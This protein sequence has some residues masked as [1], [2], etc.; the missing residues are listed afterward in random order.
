MDTV[1]RNVECVF[2]YLDDILIASSSAKQHL[3]DLKTVCERLRNFGLTIRLEK[4]L[5][6]VSSI[7]FLGH[8]VSKDG[9]VPLPSK[10]AAIQEFPKPHNVK[11]LQEF[12]GMINFYHRYISDAATI[13]RPLYCALKGKP[14]KHSLNWTDDMT[15]AFN[16]GKSALA[17]ATLLAHPRMDVPI[18][19]T[20]D[21]CDSGVGATF[22][23]F[24]DGSWQPLAFFSKQLR[25]PERKYSTFD[26]ELLALYLS[27]RHFRFL[28]EGRDFTAF[29]DHKPLVAAMCKVSDPWS[30]RQ[31]R[32]LSFISEF[33]TNVQHISGKENVV[34]DCLS[35]APIDNVSIGIDYKA[36]AEAQA[37]SEEVQ[38]YLTAITNLHLANMPVSESG[39]VLLCDISTGVPRPIV[40][41]EYR[42]LVFDTIHN[43]AHPGRKTTQ[44]LVSDKFVWHGIRK[45]VNQWAKECLQCQASKIQTHVRAPLENFTVPEKRFSHIHIDLVGPLPP[46]RGYS[47]LLT[48]VDRNT[49]WPEAIPMREI[50]TTECARALI[51]VWIA[52]FGIPLSMTSDRG[53]QFTSALWNAISGILGIQIHHT[54]AYHPQS[55]G[56]VER[57]HRT[58]KGSLKAR[59][60]GPNWIDELPWVMLGLRTAPKEDLHSSSAELVYGEP[61]TVPGDFASTNAVPRSL[62]MRLNPERLGSSV[63]IPTSAHS[64]IN[65]HVPN[66]LATARYVFIRHDAHRGPLQRPYDGPYEVISPGDKAFRI[67]VGNRE[68]LISIDRLKPAHVSPAIPVPVAQ[69]PRRGRPALNTHVDQHLHNDIGQNFRPDTQVTRAG[70]QVRLPDRFQSG[71]P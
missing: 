31:Q 14:P 43:L 49:R 22:E 8:N 24:V 23:Q 64:N 62:L 1:F 30:A 29:T 55:N 56:L 52:R 48:I 45:Q 21:A 35:R 68:E 44:K 70:R 9:S 17:S 59:L 16:E 3:V 7:D 41:P 2:V 19:V 39:P 54:T 53:P 28:L 40:P 25:E 47:Y 32:H 34:A 71:I 12:L 18:A 33:T 61:L 50:T 11:L 67:R 26:R 37:N 66:E 65:T 57:F 5:F 10:V 20:S 69:P 46:S 6:G 38:A 51:S 36:M 60:N 27:I 15:C 63:P 13:L 4:C 58:M 42:R